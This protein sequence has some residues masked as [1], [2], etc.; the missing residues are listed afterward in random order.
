MQRVPLPLAPAPAVSDCK[1]QQT[2]F[3]PV[4]AKQ[5]MSFNLI[6]TLAVG[7]A[8]IPMPHSGLRM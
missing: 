8:P 4:L 7:V 5:S 2:E 3:T 6:N 1:F